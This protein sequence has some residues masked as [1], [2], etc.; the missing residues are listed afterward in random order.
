MYYDLYDLMKNYVGSDD[1][2]KMDDS[3]NGDL[4]EYLSC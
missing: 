1:P 4:I 2:A 3:G